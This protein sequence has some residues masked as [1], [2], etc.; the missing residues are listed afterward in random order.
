V[1]AG[2]R[3]DDPTG[4]PDA[5]EIERFFGTLPTVIADLKR[6][7]RENRALAKAVAWGLSLLFVAFLIV[8]IRT[9]ING[10][11]IEQGQRRDRLS[12][13]QLCQ[14]VNANAIALNRFLDAAIR[15]TRANDTLTDAEIEARVRQYAAIKQTVP[16]C[17]QP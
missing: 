15:N 3:I 5:D 12:S 8:S 17:T 10:D 13:Y 6:G 11:D 14:D 2:R 1:N 16:A 4:D 9:E 7:R